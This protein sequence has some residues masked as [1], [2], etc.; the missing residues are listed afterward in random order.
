MHDMIHAYFIE[1]V[2]ALAPHLPQPHPLSHPHPPG[3]LQRLQHGHLHLQRLQLLCLWHC[4]FHCG[5]FIKKS[6]IWTFPAC[7]L[8]WPSWG[9]PR[10]S[11]TSTLANWRA[12]VLRC[13]FKGNRYIMIC[14]ILCHHKDS[15]CGLSLLD[16]LPANNCLLVFSTYLGQ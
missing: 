9:A 12:Q 15:Q 11:C 2:T 14:C 16:G 5:N 7:R 10:M 4:L 1:I 6:S 8:L 3:E 13:K